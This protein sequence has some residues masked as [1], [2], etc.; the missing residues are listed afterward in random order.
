MGVSMG[1]LWNLTTEVTSHTGELVDLVILGVVI[2]CAVAVGGFITDILKNS[3]KR[4]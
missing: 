1:E 2:T 3:A 4:K